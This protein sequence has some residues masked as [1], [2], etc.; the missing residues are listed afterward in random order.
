MKKVKTPK[1]QPKKKPT[2]EQAKRWLDKTSA[3][4]KQKVA[5]QIA[6]E[7]RQR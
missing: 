2:S 6:L 1:I 4:I 3:R 7:A 5:R